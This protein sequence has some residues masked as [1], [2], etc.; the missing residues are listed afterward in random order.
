[1]SDREKEQFLR[2]YIEAL[3]SGFPDANV[4]RRRVY[5]SAMAL[6]CPSA[7]NLSQAERLEIFPISRQAIHKQ[8]DNWLDKIIEIK[9]D[10]RELNA[11]RLT[12]PIKPA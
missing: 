10:S 11:P 9:G 2:A 8:V 4:L 3:I 12:L 7:E 6:D 5:S 1:M